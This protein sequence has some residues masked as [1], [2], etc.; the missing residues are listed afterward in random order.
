MKP[1]ATISRDKVQSVSRSFKSYS[2]FDCT[3][4]GIQ[5]PTAFGD[6][7]VPGFGGS[8]CSARGA[9]GAAG[10]G[11]AGLVS[12]CCMAAGTPE[13]HLDGWNCGPC[14]RSGGGS[15]AALS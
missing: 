11:P 13:H 10:D 12:E 1:A 6:A 15:H 7:T 2:A 3:I 8:R 14:G 4:L 9:H 5:V